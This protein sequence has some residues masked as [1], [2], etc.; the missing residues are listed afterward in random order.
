MMKT[1]NKCFQFA[2]CQNNEIK[3]WPTAAERSNPN[4]AAKRNIIPTL[5][6]TPTERGTLP[7]VEYRS[8]DQNTDTHHRKLTDTYHFDV[9]LAP[10]GLCHFDALC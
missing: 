9:W 10:G 5:I 4:R 6:T 1:I 2:V 7:R 8:T 3:W